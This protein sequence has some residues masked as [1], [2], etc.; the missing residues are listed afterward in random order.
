MLLANSQNQPHKKWECL[1]LEHFEEWRIWQNHWS[2]QQ[3]AGSPEGLRLI[4]TQRFTGL[5]VVQLWTPGPGTGHSCHRETSR[6]AAQHMCGTV[7]SPGNGTNP[8]KLTPVMGCRWC[9]W[10]H[11]LISMW[12]LFSTQIFLTCS[13]NFLSWNYRNCFYTTMICFSLHSFVIS[14]SCTFWT[15][16]PAGGWLQTNSENKHYNA[17]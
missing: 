2:R 15:A 10:S 6:P 3:E 9:K 4:G 13:C 17:A 11:K 12:C 5:C 8:R 1:D 14:T 7:H 16:V